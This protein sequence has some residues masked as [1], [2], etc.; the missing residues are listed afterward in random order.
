MMPEP[1]LLGLGAVGA[2]AFAGRAPNGPNSSGA[3]GFQKFE[4]FWA[5]AT[6]CPD[7]SRIVRLMPSLAFA[8]NAGSRATRAAIRY[9]V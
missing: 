3:T 9:Q 2:V 5:E 4:V 1:L 6:S 7:S 8:R